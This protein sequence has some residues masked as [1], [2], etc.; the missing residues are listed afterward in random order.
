MGAQNWFKIKLD[1]IKNEFNFRLESLILDITEKIS[2]KM[3]Q[4]GMNRVQLAQSLNVSP[5][6]VTKILNGTS[7]FTLKSLLS[8]ADALDFNLKIDFEDKTVSTSKYISKGSVLIQLASEEEIEVR[9]KIGT[10]KA[11]SSAFAGDYDI[12]A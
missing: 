3:K 11:H 9:S 5:P 1:A 6:A 4:K 2:I 12:A 10:T 7:N 8:I